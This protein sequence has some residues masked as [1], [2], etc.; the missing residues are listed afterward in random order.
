MILNDPKIQCE[1]PMKLF[2]D[3]DLAIIIAHNLVQHDMTKH[4]EIDRHFIK[5]LDSGLI[6]ISYVPSG[7][8]LVDVLTHGLP[9]ER[10]NRLTCNLGM[11]DSHSPA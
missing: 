10:L 6:T 5:K 11:I 8:Q 4:L 9:T 1:E 2:S 3:N 7:H